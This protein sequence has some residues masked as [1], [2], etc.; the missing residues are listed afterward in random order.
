[1]HSGLTVK[2][3]LVVTSLAAAVAYFVRW[4]EVLVPGTNMDMKNAATAQL[5]RYS[6]ARRGAVESLGSLQ[7]KV[8]LVVNVASE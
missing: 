6:A 1:M 7:G 2:R 4:S 8:V 5:Y 3:V